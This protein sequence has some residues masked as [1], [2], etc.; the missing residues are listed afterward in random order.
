V[1]GG[2]IRRPFFMHAVGRPALARHPG[3]PLW[4]APVG[5]FHRH[6]FAVAPPVSEPQ[7]HAPI[8]RPRAVTRLPSARACAP[9]PRAQAAKAKLWQPAGAVR[10]RR[11]APAAR[12][13]TSCG[14]ARR[15]MHARCGVFTPGAGMPGFG[16]HPVGAAL[17]RRTAVL[18]HPRLIRPPPP[19][20]MLLLPPV[21]LADPPAPTCLR[22]AW[23][24]NAVR[25]VLT[26][27][28]PGLP[29]AGDHFPLLETRPYGRGR[30]VRNHRGSR[31]FPRALRRSSRALRAQ[32]SVPLRSFAWLRPFGFAAPSAAHFRFAIARE[33]GLPRHLKE[34]IMPAIGH[35]TK[36]PDGSL[37]CVCRSVL[38]VHYASTVR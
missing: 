3:F 11:C 12:G 19:V 1:G 20:P 7:R 14:S 5:R 28:L 35:V 30:R 15:P 32:K 29:C 18:P 33:N 23:P 31:I 27:P 22:M 17:T 2:A 24:P 34:A 26:P 8:R 37:G 16:L 36:H 13:R 10:N 6:G 4:D 9:A 38:V 25:I 21:A